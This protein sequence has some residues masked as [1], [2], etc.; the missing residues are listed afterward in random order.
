MD[1]VERRMTMLK[2]WKAFKIGLVLSF[3]IVLLPAIA[4]PAV[5]RAINLKNTGISLWVFLFVG[6]VIVLLQVIPAMI[7]FFSFVGA[8]SKMVSEGKKVKENVGESRLPPK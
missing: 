6:S 8:A 3:V 1:K 4:T 5:A 2:K 7:L